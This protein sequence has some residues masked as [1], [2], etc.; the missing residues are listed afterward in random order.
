MDMPGF[1]VDKME[2]IKDKGKIRHSPPRKIERKI[3]EKNRRNKMKNLYSTLNS[4]I[5]Q[6]ITKEPLSVLD[7]VDE[8]VNYIKSLQKR[9]KEC[10]AKKEKLLGR[11]R[12]HGCIGKGS[13]SISS[14]RSPQIKVHEIGS[15]LQ[16]FLTIGLEDQFIF[17]EIIRILHEEGA[18]VKNT[19]YSVVGDRVFLMVLAEIG[20]PML[21][22]G[23]GRITAKLNNFVYGSHNEEEVLQ[24]S[25]DLIQIHP[26]IWD[27]QII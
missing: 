14:S 24:E 23:G 3:I 5:P 6:R 13:D 1:V 15:G 2:G 27:F 12:S 9:L 25:W 18:D 8:A 22:V 4:L 21:C 11:K 17:Y 20:E 10:E 16:I 7:Q 19:T 26:E